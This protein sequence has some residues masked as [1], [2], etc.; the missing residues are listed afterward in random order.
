MYTVLVIDDEDDIRKLVNM[1]LS[2]KGYT[3]VE[4]ENG[5]D[6][7]QK[8]LTHRPD[9]I[10]LDLVMPGLSGIEVCRLI[11]NKDDTKDT[12]IILFTALGRDVDRRMAK[13]AGANSYITKPFTNEFLVKEVDRL[14]RESQKWENE[15]YTLTEDIQLVGHSDAVAFFHMF[16]YAFQKSVYNQLDEEEIIQ[17]GGMM[18]PF[19]DRMVNDT[20]FGWYALD[21]PERTLTGFAELLQT[22]G[23]TRNAYFDMTSDGYNFVVEGCV[24]AEDL[25]KR[26]DLKNLFCP[27]GLYASFL[28]QKSSGKNAVT[29]TSKFKENGSTTR[30]KWMTVKPRKTRL[31]K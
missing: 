24:F 15:E 19:L 1:I 20:P 23:L 26:M 30:I 5:E 7:L 2:Q 3:V 17:L 12:P 21:D 27:Y 18:F 31:N 8:T 9:L 13:E 29:E 25:H 16:A 28:A 14:I 11:K 10:I 22:Y 6:G 4:A